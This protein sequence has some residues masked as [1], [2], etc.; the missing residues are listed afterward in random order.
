MT[1]DQKLIKNKLGLLELASYLNNVSEACWTMGYSRDTFYRVKHAYETGGMEAL[2]EKSRRV[3]NHKNRVS[4]EVEQAVLD[5]ALSDP[6]K[7]QKRAS[8]ELR[9]QGVFISPAGIGCVWL[10]HGLETFK[11]RL[12]ALEEHVARTGEVLTEEQLR[13]LEKA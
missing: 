4:E 6:S 1:T 10:R 5:L 11:K 3:P 8:D 13:A 12:K 7:S 2:R 9:Q